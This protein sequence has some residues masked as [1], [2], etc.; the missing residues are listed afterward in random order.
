MGINLWYNNDRDSVFPSLWA[1]P[2]PFNPETTLGFG[3]KQSGP[4]DIGIYDL[5]GRHVVTL[6]HGDLDPGHH[7]VQWQGR[8]AQ[9]Q[10][11]ASGVY[12]SVLKGRGFQLK[13]KLLMLK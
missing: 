5:R 2:N 9:G 6:L 3:L 1:A 10:K 12:F 8:D 4:V 11:V 7:T 13:Q